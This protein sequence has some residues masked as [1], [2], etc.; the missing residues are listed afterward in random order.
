MKWIRILTLI[1][2]SAAWAYAPV[3]VQKSPAEIEL[4]AA[5]DKAETNDAKA[6]VATA[7]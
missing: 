4:A 3:P 2:V 1:L 6:Q 7:F 5:L